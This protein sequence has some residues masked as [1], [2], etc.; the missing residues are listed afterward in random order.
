MNVSFC[1][2]LVSWLVNEKMV[3]R[4]SKIV[5]LLVVASGGFGS[6]Y[7]VARLNADHNTS[8]PKVKSRKS[9][10]IASFDG[11][12]K[13]CFHGHLVTDHKASPPKAENRKSKMFRHFWRLQVA[14]LL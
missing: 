13:C 2:W 14:L 8:Q 11:L 12:G 6:I 5:G 10:M 7:S 4:K 3:V 9:K 1:G